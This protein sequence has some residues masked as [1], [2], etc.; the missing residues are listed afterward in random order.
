MR[1]IIAKNRRTKK[2]ALHS[3]EYRIT[4]RNIIRKMEGYSE[5]KRPI[6]TSYRRGTKYQKGGF[7]ALGRRREGRRP[8]REKALQL[9]CA[10]RVND[11]R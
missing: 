3:R 7:T 4:M 10:W 8:Y 11:N 5:E 9:G 1:I 2:N 6:S